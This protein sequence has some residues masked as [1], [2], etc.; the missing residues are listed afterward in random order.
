M[1]TTLTDV[2]T[3]PKIDHDEAMV[4]AE[5]EF[6]RTLDLVRQLDAEDWQR[7]TVCEPWDVRAM[8]AHVV[9]MAEAQ[10]SFRQFAHD[11]RAASKRS[12]G[13]MIDAMTATQVRDR[14][15][16]TPAQLLEHLGEVAPR[17]V[18]ARRRTPAPVRWAVRM[19]QD[20]PFDTQRWKFGYLV[21]T[22]FTRDTWMH[23]L[24][25]SRATGREMVLTSDHDG[26]LIADVVLEWARRH[27]RPFSLVL[28]GPAGGKW[29]AAGG[30]E[31]IEMGA[32]DFCWTLAGRTPGTG[33]LETPVPF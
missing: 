16:L 10:A 21:D 24:D 7:A 31:H 6:A 28:G 13:L 17:A 4:L 11:Y 2:G 18:R 27:G 14:A 32:L 22:I 29:A 30:A 26:R 25:I 20:P 19:K 3:I 12:D 9:G 1:T 8:F 23:R 33:L 5:T 15:R